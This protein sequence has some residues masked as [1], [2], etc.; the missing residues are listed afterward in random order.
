M[1]KATKIECIVR[2]TND[3]ETSRELSLR[4]ETKTRIVER[5]NSSTGW[6]FLALVCRERLNYIKW[7]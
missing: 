5:N 1:L 7:N 6:F 3:S 2:L 4:S